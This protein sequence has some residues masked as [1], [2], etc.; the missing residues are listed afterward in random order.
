MCSN[1]FT[2]LLNK[3]AHNQ[4]TWEYTINTSQWQMTPDIHCSGVT[5]K[6]QIQTA[7][8]DVSDKLFSS[9][10]RFSSSTSSTLSVRSYGFTYT[11]L[12][13][14]PQHIIPWITSEWV[15]RFLMHIGTIR[16]YSA[17]HVGCSRK[18]RTKDKLKIQKTQNT[19]IEYNSEKANNAK[20]SKTKLP[21]FSH[22]L[23]HLTRKWGGLILQCSWV[24]TGSWKPSKHVEDY[25]KTYRLAFG[26]EKMCCQTLNRV[27]WASFW[28]RLRLCTSCCVSSGQ[29]WPLT[30]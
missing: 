12:K 20:Y 16:L 27:R 11:F 22:L 2:T 30:N 10:N 15:S 26:I 1:H 23:R 8:L 19:Q 4:T 13:T 7:D 3:P 24:H 21:W 18:Y 6:P 9:F 28:P 25:D 29:R 5:T 14:Q 17:I